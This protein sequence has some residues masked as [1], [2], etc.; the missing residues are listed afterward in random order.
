MPLTPYKVFT[1]LNLK[2]IW[3][4]TFSGQTQNDND[5]NTEDYINDNNSNNVDNDDGDDIDNDDKIMIF[6][7][8]TI[9]IIMII[10]M[11]A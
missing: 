9:M 7:E 6:R 3:I 8:P 5:D 2:S 4:H 11:M 10:V 1:H